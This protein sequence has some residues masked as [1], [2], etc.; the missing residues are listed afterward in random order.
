[1]EKIKMIATCEMGLEALVR[2]ELVDLGIKV[3][4]TDNNRVFFEGD[5][6][7][8]AKA[9]IWLRCAGRVLIVVG[10]FK[11]LTFDS[12]FDQTKALN[13]GR[14]IPKRGSF[15]VK[16][17]SGVKS[18][19]GSKS[20]LQSIVKKAVVENL[21]EKYNVNW[22]DESDEEYSIRVIGRNDYFYI[23]LDSS[24]AGLN[25]R[26]YRATGNTA[27]IK[28]TLAA[29][30][31]KLSKWTPDRLLADPLCGSGTILIEAAMIGRNMAPG[32]NREFAAEYWTT[33]PSRVFEE[34]VEKAAA[35]VNDKE[36]MM[37][38]S[39]IDYFSIKQAMENAKYAGVDKHIS[40]QKIDVSSF[41]TKKRYGVIITNPPYGVRLS[42]KEEVEDLYAKMGRTFKELKDW[43]YFVITAY[44]EFEK[45]FGMRASKK[46]KLYNGQLRCDFYQFFGA[47]PPRQEKE[48]SDESV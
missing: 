13:W 39:D 8:L 4:Q 10:E 11:A 2:D 18:K 28:E 30:L 36:F 47:L 22:L 7:D 45:A 17:A 25:K 42:D 46:R 15:P 24:G 20:D 43:S 19:L 48:K 38:G 6:N 32:L 14:F 9:N 37:V 34:E 27:S 35:A 31:V 41:R 1:M 29:A 40:F 33:I 21:K 26:G 12:L 5:Y 23:A 44:P 16:K 3:L